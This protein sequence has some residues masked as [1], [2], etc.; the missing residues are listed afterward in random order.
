MLD[1]AVLAALYAQAEAGYPEEVCGWLTDDTVMP[2][3]NELHAR[4]AYRF[5]ARD[6]MRLDE[7][8][9]SSSPARIVYH[10]HVDADGAFSA[11]DARSAA[12]GGVPLWPVDWVIVEV[13]HGLARGARHYRWQEGQFVLATHVTRA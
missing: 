3:E 11:A 7:S 12:P 6:T 8:L 2:C 9:R 10:S 1:E 4:T 5:S 13:R